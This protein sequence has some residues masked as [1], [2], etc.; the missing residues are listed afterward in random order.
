[1][2]PYV[3]YDAKVAV[4]FP[5]NPLTAVTVNNIVAYRPVAK[6]LLSRQRSLLGN[7][8]NMHATIEK[9]CYT[10]CF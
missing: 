3:K 5:V 10:T 8:R 6:R 2:R 4:K 7:A 9:P 1:M